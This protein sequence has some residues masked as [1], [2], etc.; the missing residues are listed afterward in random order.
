MEINGFEY[1][2]SRQNEK[3]KSFSKLTVSKYRKETGLF[4]AEG[5]K[6]SGEA[7]TAGIASCLLVL[8]GALDEPDVK[9][10]LD[11][12]GRNVIKYILTA[13]AFEKVS[14]ESAP[15]GMI[16]VCRRPDIHSSSDDVS[17]AD[18]GGKSVIALDGIRDPGNLGTIIRTALAFGY[19]AVIAGD[20]ADLYNPKTVRAS[21]GALFNMHLVVC[22]D[23]SSYLKE[24]SLCGR[25]VIGASLNDGADEFGS[26]P[27]E[28]SDVPVIG[29][30]GHG[31]SAG[32][33]DVCTS[34]AKIPMNPVS[35]SLNAA[36]ASAVIMWE[37]SRSKRNKNEK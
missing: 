31:I 15:Q 34:F 2:T 19:D 9:R 33:A 18:L 10:V 25:R 22:S 16:A 23:L 1:I 27:L 12:S 14:T 26:F 24:L 35:E 7:V 37:Y 8:E 32:V 17:A 28:T 11:K 5:V 13:P 4:L 3:L 30:E 6:L 20:S 21:M 29:N 36:V